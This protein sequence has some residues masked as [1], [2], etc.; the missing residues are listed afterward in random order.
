MSMEADEFIVKVDRDGARAV[1]TIGGELDMHAA[2]H[3]GHALGELVASARSIEVD[4]A[5]VTFIDSA[6]LRAL[7]AAREAA[8]AQGADLCVSAASERVSWVVQVAGVADL[9]APPG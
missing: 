1:V 3:L 7:L 6:G 5:M 9:V 2:E 8:R 4:A